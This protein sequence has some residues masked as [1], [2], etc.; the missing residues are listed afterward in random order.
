MKRFLIIVSL[1]LFSFPLLSQTLGESKDVFYEHLPESKPQPYP[2]VRESDVVWAT[3]IW[4]SIDVHELFNQFFYFPTDEARNYGKKSLP[5]I[6]W[7]AMASGEIPIF[8]DYELKIPLDNEQFIKQYMRS[9]TTRLIV[10][11][12]EDDNEEY[13]NI[14]KQKFFEGSEIFLYSL[15]ET[16]FIGKQDARQD[17]RRISLAMMEV[18]TIHLGDDV[19]DLEL[20][21]QPLFWIPM[22]DYRVRALF[23]RY[24]AYVDG[25]NVAR[26]PSWDW[27][28]VNQHY[29]AFI[30]RES[31]VANRSIGD[32][33]TG[34]DAVIESQRIEDRVFNLESDMW[35]Y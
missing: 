2:F 15:F 13:Q 32:Y 22:Q 9:D 27:V 23:A 20:G 30:T 6:I 19:P 26:Q 17:S 29:S 18:Q 35:E 33:L 14:I 4:K 31:N 16:W 34:E 8:E 10:S 24:H 12:D 21:L 5:Y 25:A 28:F 1:S 7:D 11:Y 3:H